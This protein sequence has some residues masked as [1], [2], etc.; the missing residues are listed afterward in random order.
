MI[1]FRLALRGWPPLR[2]LVSE[3]R[4]GSRCRCYRMRAVRQSCDRQ[5]AGGGAHSATRGPIITKVPVRIL[6]PVANFHDRCLCLPRDNNIN[7]EGRKMLMSTGHPD[8]R[9]LTSKNPPMSDTNIVKNSKAFPGLIALPRHTLLSDLPRHHAC[10]QSLANVP[11]PRLAS[12]TSTD[13]P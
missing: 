1:A 9:T 3:R 8:Q 2:V 6:K 13:R 12:A 5:G 7:P 11:E 10:R 4:R